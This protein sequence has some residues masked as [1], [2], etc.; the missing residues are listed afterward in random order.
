MNRAG[1]IMHTRWIAAFACGAA[2]ALGGCSGNDA[3]APTDA[4]QAPADLNPSESDPSEPD[5]SEPDPPDTAPGGTPEAQEFESA[6]EAAETGLDSA[7]AQVQRAVR[8]ASEADTDAARAAAQA[9]LGKARTDLAAAAAAARGLEAQAPSEDDARLGRARILAAAAEAAL[10][11]DTE[12][13]RAAEAGF[14]WSSRPVVRTVVPARRRL[15]DAERSDAKPSWGAHPDIR[16]ADGKIL[17]AEGR[18]GSGDWLPL[19]GFPIIGSTDSGWIKYHED[20]D[21][22]FRPPPYGTGWGTA[23]GGNRVT[24]FFKLDRDGLAMKLGGQNFGA[25]NQDGAEFGSGTNGLTLDFGR[26]MP[27]PEGYPEYYWESSLPSRTEG[28]QPEGAYYVRLS[29]LYDVDRNSEYADGRPF[30]DDDE[31]LYMSYSAYG[32]MEYIP[33]GNNPHRIFPFF[34][35]YVAFSRASGDRTADIADEDKLVSA[36]FK[37]RT[38]AAQFNNPRVGYGSYWKWITLTNQN[39]M[40]LRG[41]I[42]LTVTLNGA[43]TGISGKIT[44]MEQWDEANGYWEPWARF[45][46][47][48][49]GSRLEALNL[50]SATVSADGY[51]RHTMDVVHQ[52]QGGAYQGKFY[53]P[54]DGLEVAG[55]WFANGWP[56]HNAVMVAGSFGA[57]HVPDD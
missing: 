25:N 2:F 40:R 50:H 26:P 56:N 34:G 1:W 54:Q 41:N 36:T 6:F 23:G 57:K 10:M 28:G 51:F 32:H 45:L 17:I 27:P 4:G 55:A 42:E 16:H 49:G 20:H 7:R 30:P 53:G 11:A 8:A 14:A 22:V 12:S 24:S 29:N 19:I 47:S 48:G 15:A 31:P 37:G 46:A 18:A 38:I 9:A 43:T 39:Y 33:T 21:F 52:M 35:G 44:D 5:P 13:L 3:A